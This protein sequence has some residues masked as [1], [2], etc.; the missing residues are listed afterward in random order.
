MKK[1]IAATLLS[2]FM[3]VACQDNSS[4]LA[5]ESNEINLE[6]RNDDSLDRLQYDAIDDTVITDSNG[7]H[8]GTKT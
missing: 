4:V 2:L 7:R 3:I 5:P 6:K 1:L 8:V